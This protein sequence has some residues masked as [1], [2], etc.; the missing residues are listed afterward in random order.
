MSDNK[1]FVILSQSPCSLQISVHSILEQLLKQYPCFNIKQI[2]NR[3]SLLSGKEN[4]DAGLI[5]SIPISI[6]QDKVMVNYL[7]L[8]RREDCL[9]SLP[10]THIYSPTQADEVIGNSS[11]CAALLQWLKCWSKKCHDKSSVTHTTIFDKNCRKKL[12]K[13]KS[14]DSEEDASDPDFLPGGNS[15]NGDLPYSIQE[16]CEVGGDHISS[17][18]L[19]YGPHGSGKTAAVYACA[20]EVGFK[21]SPASLYTFQ[22]LLCG[23][24]QGI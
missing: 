4:P 9:Y 6:A 22:M 21:V 23:Y 12:R 11:A 1:S 3:Y 7:T 5:C 24:L 2:F 17:A 13:K 15:H 18:I 19:L 8:S 10:W 14:Y 20:S 16:N